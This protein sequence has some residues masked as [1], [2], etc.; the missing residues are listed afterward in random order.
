MACRVYT[1]ADCLS[2]IELT[3]D[4]NQSI[5][6]DVD[7]FCPDTKTWDYE[8]EFCRNLEPWD[9]EPTYPEGTTVW[10]E[11]S[12]KCVIYADACKDAEGN[13]TGIYNGIDECISACADG[14][15]YFME[16]DECKAANTC[17]S[18]SGEIYDAGFLACRDMIATDC[19]LNT[20]V[21]FEDVTG[22]D[23]VENTC[24]A[25]GSACTDPKVYDATTFGC[26]DKITSDCTAGNLFMEQS[27][28]CVAAD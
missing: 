1:A 23:H 20:T 22:T 18:A 5:C 15:V 11:A 14:T 25:T 7:D 8:R 13:V 2:D 9:C 21:F 10:V 16:E 3:W 19:D 17:A 24:V 6:V 27:K 28:D 26:R 4:A 12:A